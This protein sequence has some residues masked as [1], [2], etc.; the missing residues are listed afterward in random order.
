MSVAI[1]CWAEARLVGA[2]LPERQTLTVL[3]ASQVPLFIRAEIFQSLKM[4]KVIIGSS[5]FVMVFVFL[6][7]IG[8]S[9]LRRIAQLRRRYPH[10]VFE[11]VVS[12]SILY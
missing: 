8:T 5:L 4:L 9:S 11:S 1:P 2:F 6:S 3:T 7:V 12:F 10:L